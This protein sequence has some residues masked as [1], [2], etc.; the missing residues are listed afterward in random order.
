M[1]TQSDSIDVGVEWGKITALGVLIATPP[2]ICT[3]IAAR[4]DHQQIDGGCGQGMKTN[5]PFHCGAGHRADQT[6][7]ASRCQISSKLKI[8][9]TSEF[10][11]FLPVGPAMNMILLLQH[12]HGTI[13]VPPRFGFSSEPEGDILDRIGSGMKFNLVVDLDTLACRS[14]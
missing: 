2:L 14:R 10:G 1:G 5:G 12:T 13:C 9:N 8:R 3:F 7:L 11:H 4:A 6:C